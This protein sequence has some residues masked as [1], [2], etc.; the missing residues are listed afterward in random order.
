M[1]T[2]ITK[3]LREKFPGYVHDG[4]AITLTGVVAGG[5]TS[6]AAV[7]RLILENVRPYNLGDDDA[8]DNLLGFVR[9]A[10][11]HFHVEL[12]SVE[13]VEPEDEDNE[14]FAGYRPTLDPYKRLETLLDAMEADDSF[15]TIELPGFPGEWVLHIYPFGN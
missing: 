3:F 8:E 1:S 10:G 12:I 14:T 4:V 9:I 11:A 6:A 7:T 5:S 13:Q 15:Q 2:E